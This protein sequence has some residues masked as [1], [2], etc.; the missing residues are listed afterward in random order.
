GWGQE[1]VHVGAGVA[2]RPGGADGQVAGGRERSV[3]PEPGEDL[4]VVKWV[5]SAPP[6]RSSTQVISVTRM[7]WGARALWTTTSMDSDTRVLR[8]D[9]VFGVTR[10]GE[11][12]RGRAMGPTAERFHSRLLR[13]AFARLTTGGRTQPPEE[14]SVLRE[15]LVEV[16]GESEDLVP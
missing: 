8:A 7:P 6:A 3:G 12:H 4:V 5:A 16:G 9:I 11:I 14:T 2:Q 15:C 13:V 1:V 10:A